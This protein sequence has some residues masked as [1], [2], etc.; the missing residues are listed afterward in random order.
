MVLNNIIDKAGDWNPQLFRELKERFTAR[1]LGAA[2]IG[3]L[4]IQVCV[5]FIFTGQIPV[6]DILNSKVYSRYCVHS[7]V[8]E[9]RY[10]SLC[11]LDPHGNPILNWQPWWSDLFISLSW[12]LPLGLILGS[13]YMLVADLVQEEKRGTLNFIRLSPQSAQTIFM[14]KILGVPS[15]VYLAAAL[16]LPF[17][18]FA[19]IS[20]GGNILLLG[21]WYATI[22]AMWFLL[23]SAAVLYVL[24]GGIQ[25]ILTIVVVGYPI[26]T[27]LFLINHYAQLT[28]SN[29][30]M[31]EVTEHFP[32]WFWLPV[33][34]H[35]TYL[36]VFG[37]ACC[38][39]AAAWIW[40]A[41]ERRYLNPT[42]TVIGKSQSYFA[43]LCW[44]VW[45]AGFI[46]PWIPQS[47]YDK[48]S[49]MIALAVMDFAA[50]LLLIPMLLPS[51][52]SLQDW[53]R[54]RRERV[55]HKQKFWHRDIIQDLIRNDKSPSLVAISINLGMAL[56]LWVPVGLLSFSSTSHGVRF[57]GGICVAATL[58]LIYTTI[59]HL[60]LFLN[61]KKRNIWTLTIVA[62]VMFLPSVVA[63]ILSPGH[64]PTGLAGIFLLFSPFAPIGILNLAGTTIFATFAAQ[65][66]LLTGLTYQLQRKLKMTGQ[67]QSKELLAGI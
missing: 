38:L 30:K 63:L 42:A 31:L 64:N 9:H 18:L 52:Q 67:S 36:Y 40:Q 32:K 8:D 45:I 62:G 15:L 26:C 14:G 58:I 55:T 17:H 51:K 11:L 1:N 43:N 25:A 29:D 56:A 60:S 33:G 44:Q 13:V 6:A 3:S 12:I 41:I 19:G 61:F 50:L 23:S 48:E 28:L 24:L 46:L 16:M 20:A 22:G 54:Y 57:L 7:T 35:A 65:L 37:T 4:L 59:A 39:V 47:F 49:A 10:S 5:W 66:T 53:T 21:T 27:P 2:A 34:T